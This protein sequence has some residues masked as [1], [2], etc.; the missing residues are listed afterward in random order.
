MNIGHKFIKVGCMGDDSYMSRFV[1]SHSEMETASGI[2]DES[3]LA[4]S[5]VLSKKSSLHTQKMKITL[6]IDSP[7][8][9][10]STF[11]FLLYALL[12]P[13]TNN[14][15]HYG[16]CIFHRPFLL[17]YSPHK[18]DA[19]IIFPCYMFTFNFMWNIVL[20]IFF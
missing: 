15:N 7:K 4:L 13:I 1:T 3:H 18:M 17:H 20:R 2:A 6:G 9:K 19:R 14:R 8:K 11:S 16:N 5:Q 12:S 10:S